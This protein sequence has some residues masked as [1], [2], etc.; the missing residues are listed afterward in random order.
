[1]HH[2]RAC[3]VLVFDHQN[4]YAH[5]RR[6]V[7]RRERRL[8]EHGVTHDQRRHRQAHAKARTLPFARALGR[9][10][11][12]VQLRQ[13]LDDGES[14][15]EPLRASVHLLILLTKRLEQVR[16]ESRFDATP[17]VPDRKLDVGVDAAQVHGHRAALRRE[18]GRVAEQVC[19]H[20]PNARGSAEHHARAGRDGAL[21]P[22]ALG[23]GRQLHAHARWDLVGVCEGLRVSPLAPQYSRRA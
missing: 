21:Q 19:H 22:D 18:L 5:E 13:P 3:V 17:G 15:A 14:Q 12:A 16:E 9:D 4:A 23:F 6:R 7:A 1:M 11:A 2:E 10:L 20:L 8:A